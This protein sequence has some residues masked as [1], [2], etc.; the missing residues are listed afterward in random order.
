MRK[1]N[2]AYGSA[3][4]SS[5]NEFTSPYRNKRGPMARGLDSS[6]ELHWRPRDACPKAKPGQLT[7]FLDLVL[8]RK[9]RLHRYHVK[10]FISRARV[11]VELIKLQDEQANG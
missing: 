6:R 3:A 10:A 5:S 7:A 4:A 11:L 9:G 8:S 2:N 1:C